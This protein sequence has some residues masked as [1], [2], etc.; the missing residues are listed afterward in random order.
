M[1]PYHDSRLTRIILIVFF[2]ALAGY[3]YYEVQGL[4]S[5]PVIE[6]ENRV[7]EVADPF[8]MIE[9]KADRIATLSMNGKTIPVTEDGAFSEGYVL[10]SGYNRI[11]LE[12]RDR[13]GNTTEREIEIIYTPS[14][15]STR[16]PQAT[17]TP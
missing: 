12:A 5:G 10:S 16:S 8:I 4:L 6:V 2:V 7:M 1:L 3:A 11:V 9:G 14:T 17:T 13:Y 15:G